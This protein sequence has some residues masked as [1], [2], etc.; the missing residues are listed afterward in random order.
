MTETKF[1]KDYKSFVM[2]K[3]W[4]QHLQMLSDEEVGRLMRAV[5][6]LISDEDIPELGDRTITVI[7]NMM[8]ECIMRDAAKWEETRQTRR[9][10][11]AKGGRARAQNQAKLS[12]AKPGLANQ[13]ISKSEYSSNNNSNSDNKSESESVNSTCYSEVNLSEEELDDLVRQADR[14]TVERY[15]LKIIDWQ[16]KNRK[17]SSKPYIS[18]KKWIEEDGA[19]PKSPYNENGISTEEYDAFAR[20]IDFDTLSTK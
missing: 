17:Q 3:E 7:F 20:S 6:A 14:L 1:P 2:Y 4:G 5:Y 13:A 18:I 9:E 8:K 15:I 10:N 11:G 12:E 19:R 16:R